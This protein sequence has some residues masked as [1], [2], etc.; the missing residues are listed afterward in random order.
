M[1]LPG[2]GS[3]PSCNLDLSCR[4]SKVRSGSLTHCAGLGIEPVPQLFQ[5]TTN[6]IVSQ[7][8]LRHFYII[9]EQVGTMTVHTGPCFA[10]PG[11]PI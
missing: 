7:K 11:V 5:D 1:E 9:R 3:D 8:E 10:T 2:Q 6:P 4:C